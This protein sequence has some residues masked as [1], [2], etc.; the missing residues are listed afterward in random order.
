MLNA[1]A[2]IT[3]NRLWAVLYPVHYRENHTRRVAIILCT[4]MWVYVTAFKLAV[5][6]PDA[7]YYRRPEATFQCAL[8]RL[9]QMPLITAHQII[10]YDVPTLLMILAYPIVCQ[11]QWFRWI[12]ARR[13]VYPRLELI[14]G[15]GNGLHSCRKTSYK[16]AAGL[17]NSVKPANSSGEVVVK[18][19]S[20]RFIRFVVDCSN[21][22]QKE[23]FFCIWIPREIKY[24]GDRRN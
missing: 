16:S 24:H 8:N 4:V 12:R 6:I 19:A 1:H 11:R 9:Q 3:V 5:L 7:L 20:S 22:D 17:D 15:A 13:E 2:L 14:S 10:V 23:F 18:Q 21:F